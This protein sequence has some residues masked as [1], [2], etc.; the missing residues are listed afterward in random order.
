MFSLD[1][2]LQI[3]T[4]HDLFSLSMFLLYFFFKLIY[5]CLD[6]TY[7]SDPSN[8]SNNDSMFF[9]PISWTHPVW[10]SPMKFSYCTEFKLRDTI[11]WISQDHNVLIIFFRFCTKIK[12]KIKLLVILRVLFRTLINQMILHFCFRCSGNQLQNSFTKKWPNF[13]INN[14]GL[15]EIVFQMFIFVTVFNLNRELC[16]MC[17]SFQ[18]NVIEE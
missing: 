17:R 9:F 18:I 1:L 10:F 15:F 6:V 14:P 4:K 12:K 11:W 7:H 8:V 3:S 16:L 5:F 13:T 2:L